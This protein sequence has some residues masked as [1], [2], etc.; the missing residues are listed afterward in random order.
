MRGFVGDPAQVLEF[1]VSRPSLSLTGVCLLSYCR[2]VTLWSNGELCVSAVWHQAGQDKDGRPALTVR[3]LGHLDGLMDCAR[4]AR[5]LRLYDWVVAVLGLDVSKDGGRITL[6]DVEN[7]VEVARRNF[8]LYQSS[9]RCWAGGLGEN[10]GAILLHEKQELTVVPLHK[11]PPRGIAPYVLN[12][13]PVPV[14]HAGELSLKDWSWSSNTRDCLSLD[15]PTLQL[16]VTPNID[17]LM[18]DLQLQTLDQSLCVA[19]LVDEATEHRNLALACEIMGCFKGALPERCIVDLMTLLFAVD[20]SDLAGAAIKY[21]NLASYGAAMAPPSLKSFFEHFDEKQQKPHSEY[22][23]NSPV[24]KASSKRKREENSSNRKKAKRGKMEGI[25]SNGHAELT[26]GGSPV[27]PLPNGH[28]QSTN[29]I[30]TSK[31]DSCPMFEGGWLLLH[32]LLCAPFTQEFMTKELK[33]LPFRNAL[34]LVAFLERLRNYCPVLNSAC[35]GD[36]TNT[37]ISCTKAPIKRRSLVLLKHTQQA[38][39]G[40]PE[41]TL[42]VRGG[43][44]GHQPLQVLLPTTEVVVQW[45]VMLYRAHE[46][47]ILLEMELQNACCLDDADLMEEEADAA[48]YLELAHMEE[49]MR[50]EANQEA[51]TQVPVKTNVP[52]PLYST[53]IITFP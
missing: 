12:Q 53:E 36:Q 42:C 20:C 31:E 29:Q 28:D 47:A 23:I 8:K 5:L 19:R 48:D 41:D 40:R 35:A 45:Q 52:D 22:S 24:K 21:V 4:P 44:T 26:N 30:S 27:S 37:S 13:S 3:P 46:H 43:R 14:T 32:Q 10:G 33:R 16:S 50:Q 18:R 34:S 49:L 17:A 25:L 6:W 11:M 9:L 15:A 2:A 7:H 39:I 38:D 51:Q 1:Q